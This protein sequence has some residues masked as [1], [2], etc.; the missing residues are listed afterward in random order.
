MVAGTASTSSKK[1]NRTTFQP[2]L[3][4]IMKKLALAVVA[5]VVVLLPVS[6]DA[7]P[8]HGQHHPVAQR[9]IDWD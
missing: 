3:G 5:T 7:A 8:K 1:R 9:S 4:G 6:A 2:S